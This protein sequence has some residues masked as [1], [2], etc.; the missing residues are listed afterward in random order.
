MGSKQWSPWG[1][2]LE[3]HRYIVFAGLAYNASDPTN[4][5]FNIPPTITVSTTAGAD[6]IFSR[7]KGETSNTGTIILQSTNNQSSAITINQRGI[8]NVQ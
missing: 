2:H 4:E 7:V 8:I 5:I 6:I 3:A 1:V